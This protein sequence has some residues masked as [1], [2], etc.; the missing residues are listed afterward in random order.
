[1]DNN[2]IIIIFVGILLYLLYN[3]PCENFAYNAC[4]NL[5]YVN[6]KDNIPVSE[7]ENYIS[8]VMCKEGNTYRCYH[9]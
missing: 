9:N 8:S 3:K 2:L 6:Y 1:M 5:S 7:C 4:D